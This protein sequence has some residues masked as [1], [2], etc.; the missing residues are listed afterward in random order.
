MSRSIDEKDRIQTSTAAVAC[1]LD[2]LLEKYIRDGIVST[3]SDL[4]PHNETVPFEM[5]LKARNPRSL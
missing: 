3:R 4:S 1:T 2:H 5:S